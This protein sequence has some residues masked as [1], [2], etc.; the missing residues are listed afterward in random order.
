MQYLTTTKVANT[1]SGQQELV[2]LVLEQL[3]LDVDFDVLDK[4]SNNNVD[5]LV[6]CIQF[7][8]PFF[9]VSYYFL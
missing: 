4:E 1:L 2:N 5:K 8:L 9:S 6:T 7:I 3:E